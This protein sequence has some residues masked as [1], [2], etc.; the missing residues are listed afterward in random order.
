[1]CISFGLGRGSTILR[2][3]LHTHRQ[4]ESSDALY[5]H[6]MKYRPPVALRL[7]PRCWFDTPLE[8]RMEDAPFGREALLAGRRVLAAGRTYTQRALCCTAFPRHVG[9]CRDDQV[10]RM[11]RAVRVCCCALPVPLWPS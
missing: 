9:S 3:T 2:G 8:K 5:R 4:M 11:C 10:V 6:A 7:C 1:M